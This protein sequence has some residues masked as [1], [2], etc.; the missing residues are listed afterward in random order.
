M[1]WGV[2]GASFRGP[3][4]IL[5]VL[6]SSRRRRGAS[7][8]SWGR[9]GVSWGRLGPSWGRLGAVLGCL[10]AVLGVRGGVPT[11][12]PRP[13]E[14]Y[15]SLVA[16][17]YVGFTSRRHPGTSRRRL[18]LRKVSSISNFRCFAAGPS[19]RHGLSANPRPN[20]DRPYSFFLL[21]NSAYSGNACIVIYRWLL[22]T[23]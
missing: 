18:V 20:D 11:K 10:G 9:L 12:H 8:A 7:R 4:G 3:R 5:G 1:I 6:G 16:R 19:C 22:I 23:R 2:P 14:S 17:D 21:S 15:Q 13:H